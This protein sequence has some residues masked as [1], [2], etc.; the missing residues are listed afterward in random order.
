MPPCQQ[1]RVA[2]LRPHPRNAI[3]VH[4]S[5]RALC[6]SACVSAGSQPPGGN[7][8]VPRRVLQEIRLSWHAGDRQYSPIG[9]YEA[10][11][12]GSEIRV[13]GVYRTLG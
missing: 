4:P 13:D 6:L 9:L 11:S 7:A 3:R 1:R 5:R 8:G 10:S 2:T 12:D